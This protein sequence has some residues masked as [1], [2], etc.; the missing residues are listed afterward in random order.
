[1]AESDHHHDLSKTSMKIIGS[2][3]PAGSLVTLCERILRYYY[4]EAYY[5]Q[6]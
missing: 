2:F 3:G 1:M 4:P 5:Q 6:N